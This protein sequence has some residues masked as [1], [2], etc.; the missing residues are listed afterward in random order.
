MKG[1]IALE[2]HFGIPSFG[3]YASDLAAGLDQTIMRERLLDVTGRRLREMDEHGIELAVLSLTAQGAQ[4][5]PDAKRAVERAREANDFLAQEIVAKHP[6]RFAGFAS[7]ALQDPIAAGDELKRAVTQ[8][9]FK[10]AMVNGYSNVVDRDTGEYY[11]LPKFF[12]FWERVETVG[13]PVYLHPRD[14]LP[15]QQLIYEGHPALLGPAWA[16]GVETA[17]HALRLILGGVFDRFPGVNVILGHMGEM[18][19]FAISRVEQRVAA[20][21][22]TS[23]LRR[24]VS[25]Y[26]QDNFYI[27][28][29]G[30]FR[31]QALLNTMLEVGCDRILFAVDYPYEEMGTA[32][33]WFDSCPISEADRRKIGRTNAA[34]LLKLDVPD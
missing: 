31:T 21:P 18:L 4:A 19:P 14:P 10:G 6:E 7:V 33:G 2:E 30:N 1:K 3:E 12:P 32:S 8:L 25:R 9:G 11:D 5:E 22:E 17:T 24:P 27:T 26:L 34:R 23:K 16:W 20:F 13:V 15:S 28:T 29:S